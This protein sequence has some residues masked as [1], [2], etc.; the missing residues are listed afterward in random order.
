MEARCLRSVIDEK[1]I[2]SIRH[3]FDGQKEEEGEQL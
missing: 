3:I 2:I 1:V